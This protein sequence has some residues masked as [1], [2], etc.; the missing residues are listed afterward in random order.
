VGSVTPYLYFRRGLTRR[1]LLLGARAFRVLPMT[2]VW[3]RNPGNYIRELAIELEGHIVCDRGY[4]VRRKL[5]ALKMAQLH[6]GNTVPFRLLLV[7]PQGTAELRLGHDFKNPFAVYPTWSY[8]EE[9]S[10]LEELITQPVGQDPEICKIGVVAPDETPVLGQ[11]HRVVITDLPNL[12]TGPGRKFIM[13]LRELQEDY[14]DCI[15]HLHGTSSWRRAFG[16]G[17]GA[18]DVNPRDDAAH[19]KVILPAGKTLLWEKTQDNPKWVTVLGFNP[20]DLSI[21]SNRCR[22]NIRSAIWAGANYNDLYKLP[23][24]NTKITPVNPDIPEVAPRVEGV[25]LFPKAPKLIGDKFLCNSCSVQES[26]SYYREG[27][28]CSVPGAEPTPLSKYFGT[29]D[30]GLIMEGLSTLLKLQTTRLASGLRAEEEDGLDPEVTKI[31]NSL[32]DRGVTLAKLV[33]PT[34]R[35]PKLAINVGPGGRAMVIGGGSPH[36]MIGGIV[37]AL[38]AKGIARKDITPAMIENILESMVQ[39]KGDTNRAIEGTV[40]SSKDEK[41]A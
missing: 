9:A 3:F 39:Q 10:L 6:F 18:A 19:G 13:Y 41:T 24:A 28:V 23:A 38:E 2:E 4:L 20:V 22:Y 1:S 14:P 30:S 29:R 25:K 37:T 11:E 34:L 21:P 5:D 27:A 26:C 32:F 16:S 8:G 40:I 7:G 12:H 31:I 15:I 35:D 33:D 17:L 36:Q